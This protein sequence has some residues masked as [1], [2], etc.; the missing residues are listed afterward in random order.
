[1]HRMVNGCA[2]LLAAA[3][4]SIGAALPTEDEHFDAEP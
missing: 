3:T 4:L 2:L 1:M